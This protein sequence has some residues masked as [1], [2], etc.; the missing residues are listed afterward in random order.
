MNKY[1]ELNWI[2]Y[3][4]AS[5]DFQGRFVVNT[6]QIKQ[7][8]Y[9]S[10]SLVLIKTQSFPYENHCECD[11][12]SCHLHLP[13]FSYSYTILFWKIKSCCDLCFPQQ[14]RS[15]ITVQLCIQYNKV[16]LMWGLISVWITN[17]TQYLY[18]T[19]C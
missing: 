4:V 1:I 2:P 19:P 18:Y 8:P 10:S 5:V 12:S 9:H 7:E 15:Q 11:C 3:M 14:I 6:N 16:I 13:I 17:A